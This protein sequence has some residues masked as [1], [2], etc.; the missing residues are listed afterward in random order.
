MQVSRLTR[1]RYGKVE[2][3]R[4][5]RAGR[6]DNLPMPD[7]I[8]LMKSVDMPVDTGPGGAPRRR[9]T[10]APG[11]KRP[12]PPKS[13]KPLRGRQGGPEKRG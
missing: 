10:Q 12:R 5:V 2:L 7:V 3:P 13:S 1:V 8:N 4:N 11:D 9:R 6:W